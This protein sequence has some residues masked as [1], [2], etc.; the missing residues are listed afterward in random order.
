M[1]PLDIF[2]ISLMVPLAY[3]LLHIIFH[4]T[5]TVVLLYFGGAVSGVFSKL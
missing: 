3:T 1:D 5:S 4:D 2:P